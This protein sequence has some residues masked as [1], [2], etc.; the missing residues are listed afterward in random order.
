LIDNFSFVRGDHT[1]KFGANVFAAFQTDVNETFFGGRFNFGAAIPLAN[2]IALNPQL[3]PTTLS[4]LQTFL[5]T[6]NSA[7]LPNLAV[8]INALQSFNLGLPIVYQQGFGADTISGNNIRTGFT[9]KILG[10]SAKI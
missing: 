2:I 3:P 9:R 8:P 1:I 6:N 7:L 10:K 4:Q 5:A